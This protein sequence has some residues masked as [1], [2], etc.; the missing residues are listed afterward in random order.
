MTV[1][2]PHF[3]A[4]S[5]IHQQGGEP[6]LIH[7]WRTSL[8]TDPIHHS[9]TT[10]SSTGSLRSSSVSFIEGVVICVCTAAVLRWCELH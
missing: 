4:H 1:E 6:R 9:T 2:E 8:L 10:D 7:Q 3:S 5:T